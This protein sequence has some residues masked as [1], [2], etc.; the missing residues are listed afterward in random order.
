MIPDNDLFLS[1]ISS[2]NIQYHKYLILEHH[3]FLSQVI[4][5][6]YPYKKILPQFLKVQLRLSTNKHV[7]VEKKYKIQSKYCRL[8]TPN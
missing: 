5:I 1:H 7:K 4:L 6:K 3:H 8:V 2:A